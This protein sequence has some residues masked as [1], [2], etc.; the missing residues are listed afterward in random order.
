M[1]HQSATYEVIFSLL[2]PSLVPGAEGRRKATPGVYFCICE[3]ISASPTGIFSVS[4][5]PGARLA[6]AYPGMSY[7]R[8]PTL[9]V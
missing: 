9:H 5:T 8:K 2:T 4:S 7:V 1:N 3:L 6:H